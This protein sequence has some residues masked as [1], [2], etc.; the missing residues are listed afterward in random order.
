MTPSEFTDSLLPRD[1][2]VGLV[3]EP[4]RADATVR[5]LTDAGF[6]RGSITVLEGDEAKRRFGLDE[7]EDGGPLGVLK[8]AAK[9]LAVEAASIERLADE[10]RGGRLIAVHADE[11]GIARAQDVLRAQGVERI[12]RFNHD[13]TLITDPPERGPGGN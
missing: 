5:A 9:L 13:G 12:E 10:A 2:V 8:G 3:H 7:Q 4:E 1:Y 6:P 11:T